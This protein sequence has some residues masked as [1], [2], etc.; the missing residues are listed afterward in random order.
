M[1]GI[2]TNSDYI[3]ETIDNINDKKSIY[4]YPES[5]INRSHLSEKQ[6]QI[7]KVEFFQ[8]VNSASSF[9]SKFFCYK[10]K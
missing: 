4:S 7:N 5:K 1:L 9:W 8:Y 3:P 10:Y 2:K 6:G